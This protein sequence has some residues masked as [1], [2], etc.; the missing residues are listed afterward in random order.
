MEA[1]AAGRYSQLRRRRQA[2]QSERHAPHQRL[3]SASGCGVRPASRTSFDPEMRRSAES[4]LC[5]HCG[6]AGRHDRL[7][8]PMLLI[9][10]PLLDPPLE[11]SVSRLPSASSSTSAAASSRL[12][13]CS[14]PAATARSWP[15]RPAQ[16]PARRRARPAPLRPCPAADRPAAFW[17]QSRGRQST[18]STGSAGCRD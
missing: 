12:R 15:D 9:L 1:W 8:R 18:C 5:S 4:D 3:A 11:Q 10:G 14:S 2:R 7:K 17:R 6:A 13:R 16:S